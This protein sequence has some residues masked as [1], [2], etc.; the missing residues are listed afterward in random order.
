MLRSR[1]S[2]SRRRWVTPTCRDE[3]FQLYFNDPRYLAMVEAKFG[4][5]TV[6]EIREMTSHRLQR[7]QFSDMGAATPI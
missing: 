3:A 6:H 5:A 1:Y 4:P 7:R 2:C